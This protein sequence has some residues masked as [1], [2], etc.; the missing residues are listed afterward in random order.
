M[1]A[2][3]EII[4]ARNRLDRVEESITQSTAQAISGEKCVGVE[5]CG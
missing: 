1:L 3:P 2:P 4:A 5:L